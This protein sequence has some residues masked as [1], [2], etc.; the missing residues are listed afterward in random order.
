MTV[1]QA[2][3]EAFHDATPGEPPVR[4][5]L[6]RP[7]ARARGGLVLTHGAGSDCDAP[8]LVGLA[9]ALAA[10]QVA[11]LRCDLPYRQAR[12]TGPPHR[13]DAARD[14][15]GLKR[16]IGLLRPLCPGPIFLG[17][18]SYGGRQASM[19]A[20]E[21]PGLVDALLLL[22][23]PLH[24]PGRAT[25][26]RTS[27]FPRLRTPTLFAHG[28][29]DPFGTVDELEAARRLIPARTA[30][31]VIEGAGHGLGR[32]GRAAGPGADTIERV[33]GEFLAVVAGVTGE[34]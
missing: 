28:S 13:G 18:Q 10:R 23:Y 30:L 32:G 17:G 25:Q 9:A 22:S 3:S 14:R 1:G 11:V 27:H 33:V 24:P 12:R 21:E 20:A 4:G 2:G 19:L 5:F 15:E 8:M 34:A 7:A 16:A 31:I 26:L 29:V 6:H